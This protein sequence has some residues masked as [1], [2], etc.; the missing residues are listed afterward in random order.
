MKK[1]VCIFTEGFP[2]GAQETF[3]EN[4]LIYLAQAFKDV[5][6]QPLFYSTL[7]DREIDFKNVQVLDPV[8]RSRKFSCNYIHLLLDLKVLKLIFKA[9]TRS[10]SWNFYNVLKRCVIQKK[11][12]SVIND[13]LKTLK[14]ENF[15]FYWGINA[16]ES[17]LHLDLPKSIKCICRFHGYDLY[18]KDERNDAKVFF[19]DE[20]IQTIDSAVCI[21]KH[22]SNYLKKIYPQYSDK[23]HHSYLGVPDRGNSKPSSDGVFRILSCSN[24]YPLKR[25]DVIAKALKLNQGLSIEWCHIGDGL[26]NHT[27]ALEMLIKELPPTVNV[28]LLGRISNDETMAYYRNN[29]VDL[30]LNVSESEGVPVSIMEALS[31][32]VPVLATDVGGT[33]EIVDSEVGSLLNKNISAEYLWRELTHFYSKYNLDLDVRARA[34]TLWSE[35]FDSESNYPQFIERH[36]D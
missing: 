17:L 36:L 14:V 34:K 2:Y 9:L 28:K 11:T 20:V 32:G 23:I 3:I 21:S 35:R 7:G 29:A 22:G 24:I 16:V 5:Y 19:R 10:S 30:F 27:E 31:M 13:N 12:A 25:L 15:Y 33:S 8:F 6:I 1:S 18:G 26:D 4:E